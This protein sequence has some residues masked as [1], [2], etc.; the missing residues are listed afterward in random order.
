MNPSASPASGLHHYHALECT[1]QHMSNAAKLGLWSEVSRLED[2]AKEQVHA[3]KQHLTT[4]PAETPRLKRSRYMALQA[5]LRLDAQ[6]RLLMEPGWRTVDSAMRS[7][8]S[9]HD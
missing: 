2:V 6:V 7:T 9:Q 3:L 8:A 4:N 5:I 1:A